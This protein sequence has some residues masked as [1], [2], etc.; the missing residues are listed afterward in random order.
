MTAPM[1]PDQSLREK[2]VSGIILDFCCEM[3][4]DI[5]VETH[6]ALAVLIVAALTEPTHTER[7]DD[8]GDATNTRT[9]LAELRRLAEDAHT[10][11]GWEAHFIER[12]YP[13]KSVPGF[14]DFPAGAFKEWRVRTSWIHGQAKDKVSVVGLAS[15]VG[16]PSVWLAEQDAAFIA[17]ANPA[18]VLSLLDALAAAEARA[19]IMET[20][21]IIEVA[22]RNPSVSDY[23]QHWETRALAA[24]RDRDALQ[25]RLDEAEGVLIGAM[26][27]VDWVLS[28]EKI[29]PE[30]PIMS[31]VADA[32]TF[33]ASKE[34][35]N[36]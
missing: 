26:K 33:I 21:G 5:P 12:P 30:A 18:T 13:A 25:A 16:G 36:G 8:I 1:T 14:A 29:E 31:G 2:V 9:D 11:G 15:G 32:R 34:T 10:S 19:E 27:F 17:A 20:G 22:I 28:W 7:P 23:V 6:D 4:A 35:N 24:E 3:H